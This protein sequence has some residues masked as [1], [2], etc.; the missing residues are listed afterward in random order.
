MCFKDLTTTINYGKGLYTTKTRI[1][2]CQ[3]DRTRCLI[4][5]DKE[6]LFIRGD[7]WTFLKSGISRGSVF[8]EYIT[9]VI[10]NRCG[11]I[12]R[13]IMRSSNEGEKITSNTLLYGMAHRE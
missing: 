4:T 1:M 8:G 9:F 6:G 7:G 2:L 3:N 5:G 12:G 10:V 11:Q 13:G